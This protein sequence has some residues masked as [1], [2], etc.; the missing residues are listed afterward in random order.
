M[1]IVTYRGRASRIR[2]VTGVELV[3]MVPIEIP[4]SIARGLDPA[5]FDVVLPVPSPRARPVT[6]SRK[7]SA[8]AKRAPAE[9]KES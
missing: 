9:Q 7:K 1:A 8:V 4:A 3:R 5:D 6:R 2:I